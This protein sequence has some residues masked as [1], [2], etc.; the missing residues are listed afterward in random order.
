M[1]LLCADQVVWGLVDGAV[2]NADADAPDGSHANP[3]GSV[4]EPV[5]GAPEARRRT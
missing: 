4:K 2:A 5:V 3:S 1:L